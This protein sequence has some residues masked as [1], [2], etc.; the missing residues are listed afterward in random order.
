MDIQLIINDITKP[1]Q[2]NR[3]NFDEA[4]VIYAMDII[5]K[6]QPIGRPTLIRKLGLG[7]ATVKTLLKRLKESNIIK[8]DKVGGA[9][10]TELGKEL[11]S[12]WNSK[13]SIE[14]TELKSISW[15]S[16]MIIA[17]NEADLLNKIK[18]TQLRD[19]IIKAGANAALIA[20]IKSNEIEL[21]PKTSE[22]SIP[23]LI[24]EIKKHCEK[25]E[26]NDL[27]VFITPDDIHLAYKVGLILFENRVNS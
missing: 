9:E 4:H 14:K 12:E 22:F 7:E 25:C 10:L 17:K 18:V 11:L 16:M 24:E 19:M 13:I 3:P 5:Y 6:E 8:V 20:I 27:I 23:G 26:N 21:P 1:K 2:G 15:N